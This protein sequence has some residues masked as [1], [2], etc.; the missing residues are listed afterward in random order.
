M[1]ALFPQNTLQKS[2]IECQ[3]VDILDISVE[4]GE[5]DTILSQPIEVSMDQAARECK[6]ETDH[7][8]AHIP[9]YRL[10]CF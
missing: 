1:S 10:T 5:Y 6:V 3:A 4:L 8:D 9:S 7:I 2:Q